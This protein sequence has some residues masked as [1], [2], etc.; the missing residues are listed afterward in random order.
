MDAI[1]ERTEG[2]FDLNED[3]RCLIPRHDLA[4]AAGAFAPF[5]LDWDRTHFRADGDPA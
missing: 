3:Q 2:Q 5:A 1:C 4:F